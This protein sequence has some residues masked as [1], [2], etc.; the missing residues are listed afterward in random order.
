M[1][2]PEEIAY[3]KGLITQGQ[4]FD[5]AKRYENSNYGVYLARLVSKA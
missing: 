1:C 4:L 3:S 5:N 2:C